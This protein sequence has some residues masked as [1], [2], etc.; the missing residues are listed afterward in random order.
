MTYILLADG[1]RCFKRYVLCL[2]FSGA[3]IST[4]FLGI[5]NPQSLFFNTFTVPGNHPWWMLDTGQVLAD[6]GDIKNASKNLLLAVRELIQQSFLP[7]IIVTFYCLYQLLFSSKRP[8]KLTT[9]LSHNRWTML[10]I[11]SLFMIPT[12]ILGRVKLGGADNALSYTVYFL[13]AAATLVIIKSVSDSPSLDD[14][15]LGEAAK[16][17]VAI[18][19][20]GILCINIPSPGLIAL[21]LQ[22][23]PS[24]PQ[25]IAYEYAKKHPGEAYFPWNP[26]SSLMAEGKLY[27]FEYGLFD[28]EL[29]GFPVSDDH[30]RAY[31]PPNVRIIAF[32]QRN[33]GYVMRFLPEFS[34][35]I[36]VDELPGFS[37]YTKADN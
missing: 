5:F 6:S 19:L 29:A 4:V 23:L 21:K 10:V 34:R 25:Q 15:I 32:S 12:S 30:F 7:A 27:H 37:V 33:D 9:W 17:L 11:V 22:R 20:V 3:V 31:I 1:R 35:R 24:N 8:E 13:S 16:L 18:G 26:L 36:K 2:C 28:R 14:R